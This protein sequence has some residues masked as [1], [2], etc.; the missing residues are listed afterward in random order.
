MPFRNCESYM[1]ILSHPMYDKEHDKPDLPTHGQIGKA[2]ISW[3]IRE[4][5]FLVGKGIRRV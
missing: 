4:Q 3:P 2:C 5:R 1:L